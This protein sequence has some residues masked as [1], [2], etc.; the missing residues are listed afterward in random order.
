MPGDHP[1]RHEVCHPSPSTPQNRAGPY[2]CCHPPPHPCTV[3]WNPLSPGC[4]ALPARLVTHLMYRTP[5]ILPPF[6][7]GFHQPHLTEFVEVKL[8]RDRAAVFP[9]GPAKQTPSV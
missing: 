3:L 1:Q 9:Q 4:P 5:P 2:P 8:R 7:R 6:G